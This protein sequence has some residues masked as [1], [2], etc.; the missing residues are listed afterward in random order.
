MNPIKKKNG[1]ELFYRVISALLLL[2]ALIVFIFMGPIFLIILATI[3]GALAYFE[4][5]QIVNPVNKKF[6]VF[7]GA[8]LSSLLPIISYWGIDALLIAAT[9]YLASSLLYFL[10][11]KL[12]SFSRNFK[13]IDA[14]GIFYTGFPISFAILIHNLNDGKTL[15]LL[16][17]TIIFASDS[18]SYFI[19]KLF[20]KHFLAPSIS[21]GKTWEGFIGG[22]IGTLLT[23]LFI[24]EF[25][26]LELSN[27]DKLCIGMTIGLIAPIGDLLESKFKRSFNV[28]NSGILIPGHGG[29]LDRLDSL[30]FGFIGGYII[31]LM[32]L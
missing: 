15:L 1:S 11:T 24:P 30:G 4:Y 31:L 3:I 13:F 27:I 16:I 2:P 19:G 28:K 14:I 25:L 22:L 21:A 26:S 29:L 17:L 9:I 12:L 32:V 6:I 8:F 18:F 5:F 20:G 7:I 23:S 10:A